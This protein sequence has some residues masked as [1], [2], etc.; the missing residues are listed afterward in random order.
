MLKDQ[1]SLRTWGSEIG[2][3]GISAERLEIFQNTGPGNWK[4]GYKC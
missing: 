2:S 3:L 1:K 4:L